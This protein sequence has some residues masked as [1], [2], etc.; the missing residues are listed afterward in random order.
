MKISHL[1]L[2]LFF[3][4]S[5]THLKA[6]IETIAYQLNGRNPDQT[7]KNPFGKFIGEWTL[8]NDDWTHN[9]GNGT[10]TIKI[11]GHHTVTKQLNTDNSL[12]SIIDGPEPNGHI[13]WSYNPKTGEVGHLSS[14]GSIRAGKGKGKINKQGDVELKLTFEGETPGTYRI[15]N[16]QWVN[17][18]EYHMRSIQYSEDDEPTGL[19]YEGC[20][21]R[22]KKSEDPN[23]AVKREI[24]H[25]G[26]VIREAFGNEDIDKIKAL[27]HPDVMKALGYK[28]LKT[29]RQEVIQSLKGTLNNFRLEF[30]ENE[31][32]SI[33]VQ[34]DMAIEQ[35]RFSIK[36]TPKDG[37]DPWVFSG[38][39]VVTYVRYKDSPTGWATIREIIQPAM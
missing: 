13:F 1:L 36:G 33:L 14:F 38:R 35:T 6:Q 32:E 4:V 39:T 17:E 23:E 3:L 37:G 19:F 20:F 27:H 2:P 25:H 5:V 9:W 29:G 28:D 11:S 15:Y 24:L 22:L 26:K 31:V 21:V 10:E 34:G 18:D 8:K 7:D 16:Y 12:L 30:I